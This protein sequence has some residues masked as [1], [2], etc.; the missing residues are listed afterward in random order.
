MVE[1]QVG[2][3]SGLHTTPTASNEVNSIQGEVAFPAPMP[4]ADGT[5][6]AGASRV[7]P[8]LVDT[9]RWRVVIRHGSVTRLDAVGG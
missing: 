4:A 3:M 1:Q 5:Q 2:G 6:E 7:E 8:S 9:S